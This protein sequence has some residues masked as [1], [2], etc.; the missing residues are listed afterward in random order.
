MRILAAARLVEADKWSSDVKTKHHTPEGLFKDGSVDEIAKELK[1]EH[2]TD[3]AGA[4]SALNFYINRGGD[5]IPNKK[6]VEGAKEKLRQ[7]YGKEEA[8]SGV[9]AVVVEPSEYAYPEKDGA[10]ALQTWRSEKKAKMVSTSDPSVVIGVVPKGKNYRIYL[11]S[12]DKAVA[13]VFLRRLAKGVYVPSS[14]AD[15][16]VRGQGLVRMLYSW[17]LNSGMTLVNDGAQSPYSHGLW[18]RLSRDYPLVAFY[19][20]KILKDQKALKVMSDPN[21][22]IALLGK[23]Q[24]VSQLK[25]VI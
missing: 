22:G 12:E 23:G 17:V 2:G 13:T 5:D 6:N 3:F 25:K 16:S 21:Y 18:K 11:I 15:L 7:L 1:R 14:F 20:G 8:S 24:D 10:R 9:L 19:Y 4:M